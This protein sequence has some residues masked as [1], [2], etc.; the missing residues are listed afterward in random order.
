[1][2]PIF[3]VKITGTLLNDFKTLH[4]NTSKC[5][6]T[7]NLLIFLLNVLKLLT[8]VPTITGEITYEYWESNCPVFQALF[9]DVSKLK[10]CCLQNVQFTSFEIRQIQVFLP[11]VFPTL[12]TKLLSKLI[13][14][15]LSK[16]SIFSRIIISLI[17]H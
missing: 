12:K 17:N 16:I 8:K 15:S 2:L 14:H 9:L 11:H 3:K 10:N 1:M 4:R 7:E 5:Y 13:L 6:F